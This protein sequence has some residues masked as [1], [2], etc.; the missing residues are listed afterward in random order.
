MTCSSCVAARAPGSARKAT[1]S[2]ISRGVAPPSA[3]WRR[4]PTAAR[5]RR[6]D[7]LRDV[8]APRRAIRTPRFA[9]S[10]SL[11]RPLRPTG[12]ARA[13]AASTGDLDQD[14][15]R[16]CWMRK[17]P[18]TNSNENAE[19]ADAR[20]HVVLAEASGNEVTAAMMA[21]LRGAVERYLLAGARRGP[22]GP[23][24]R[25][26]SRA[27][28]GTIVGAVQARDPALVPERIHGSHQWL[29]LADEL[30]RR[31]PAARWTAARPIGRLT[32]ICSEGA[33]WFDDAYPHPAISL[34]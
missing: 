9:W 32:E 15:G 12:L 13:R 6:H 33:S 18:D 29:L 28:T 21:E 22:R 20:F 7:Q 17:L 8:D 11:R 4:R 24:R 5:C 25:R 26:A 1:A 23:R 10:P 31:P 3:T 30:R 2:A 16:P 14:A 34:R 19:R 27:S